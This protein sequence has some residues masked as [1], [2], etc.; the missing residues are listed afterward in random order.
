MD[1]SQT[2]HGRALPMPGNCISPNR[3]A[4]VLRM[5][6]LAVALCWGGYW[7]ASFRTSG[8]GGI[9]KFSDLA[10]PDFLAYGVVISVFVLPV[11]LALGFRREKRAWLT[12]VTLICLFS[13]LSAETWA[14]IEEALWRQKAP[15]LVAEAEVYP[16]H[17]MLLGGRPFDRDMKTVSKSRWWPFQNHSLFFHPQSGRFGGHD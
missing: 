12:S 13:T 5:I 1:D 9:P 2:P 15:S 14:G 17:A 7:T 10:W 8:Y 4:K 3:R 11:A 16:L 6:F